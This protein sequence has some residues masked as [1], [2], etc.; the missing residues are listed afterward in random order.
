MQTRPLAGRQVAEI[1]LGCM[2]F[3][4][5]YGTPPPREVARAVMQAAV[6]QGVTHFDTA[7]LYGFGHNEELVGEFVRPIRQR[8]VLASKGGMTTADGKR[9]IDGRPAALRRNLEESLRR[10]GTDFIDLY[11]MH[12]WDKNVPIEECVG[13]LAE[14]VRAGQ[15]RGIGLSEVSAETLRKAHA[16]HPIAAVQSEYSLW[17]R[18]PEIALLDACRELG[19]AFVAFSPLGRGFLAG[20]VQD[21]ATLVEKDFRLTLPRFQ[22][23]HFEKNRALLQGVDELAREARC[24]K[25]QLAL[26][27]MLGKAPHV[28]PIVGTNSVAH[29]T[30]NLASVEVA[31]T[32]D[33]L[34]R[35]EAIFTADTVSGDRYACVA[36][37]EIDTEEFPPAV[38]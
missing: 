27:W 17:T 9:V 3:S 13:A 36:Q 20:G 1:G 18:N 25:A 16:V 6:D 31:L 35:L 37:A 21:A 8:I 32:A 11:Y 15:I 38:R 7:A 28:I 10:L 26:A 29:L 2:T 33:L 4:H 24:T 22:A 34:N 14:R 19:T 30:E 12:R 5:G 23:Q